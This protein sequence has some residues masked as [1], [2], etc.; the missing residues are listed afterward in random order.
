MEYIRL[1]T[2]VRNP[3]W[4]Y[5]QQVATRKGMHTLTARWRRRVDTTTFSSH[6]K[7]RTTNRQRTC[8]S[9]TSSADTESPKDE[10]SD[11]SRLGIAFLD[12]FLEQYPGN[13]GRG[14]A[15]AA[16]RPLLRHRKDAVPT[17]RRVD[18]LKGTIVSSLRR[19]LAE[20]FP[21]SHPPHNVKRNDIR[22]S[23][24]LVVNI[25]NM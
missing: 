24:P 3:N 4:L 16:T 5:S 10:V 19:R 22:Y 1:S 9:C 14:A 7:H 6:P 11:C 21:T 25:H 13:D 20:N 8:N 18:T 12:I 15:A 23:T 17:R 2:D